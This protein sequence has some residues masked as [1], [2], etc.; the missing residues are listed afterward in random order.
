[1]AIFKNQGVYWIDYYVNGRRKRERSG[2]DKKLAETTL[3][4]RKVEIAEG[5][6]IETRTIPQGSFNE[7]ADL[8]LRWVQVNHRG[9]V[10]TRSRVECGTLSAGIWQSSAPRHHADAGGCPCVETGPAPQVCY[11]ES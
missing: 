2:P 5:K 6:Y 7:L 3:K 1:M 10:G 4:K 11:R 9:Y 8:Y